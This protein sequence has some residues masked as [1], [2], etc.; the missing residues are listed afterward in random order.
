MK[1]DDPQPVTDP[2]GETAPPAFREYRY[3]EA[4]NACVVVYGW[5]QAV[6]TI[7]RYLKGEL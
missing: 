3:E 7:E 5:E 6:E 4:G 2:F 1:A